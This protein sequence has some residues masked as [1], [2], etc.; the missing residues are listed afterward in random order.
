MKKKIS[1]FYV[2]DSRKNM[3]GQKNHKNDEVLFINQKINRFVFT[4]LL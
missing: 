3:S 2:E 4:L 1:C